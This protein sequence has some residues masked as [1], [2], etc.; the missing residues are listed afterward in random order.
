MLSL[1]DRNFLSMQRWVQFVATGA[2]LAWRVKKRRQVGARSLP[3]KTTATLPDR[4]HL[5]RLR[6]LSPVDR[7]VGG[8]GA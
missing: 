7:T 1:A 6:E 8:C 4:S 3:A 2:H 5:V